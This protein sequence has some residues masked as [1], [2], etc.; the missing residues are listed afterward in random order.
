MPQCN[1]GECHM[2]ETHLIPNV[3]N[4]ILNPAKHSFTLYGD[5]YG[6]EDGTCIRD[7]VHVKD[8]ALAHLLALDA[9]RFGCEIFN[10]GYGQG[11]SNLEVIKAC[12]KACGEELVYNVSSR[13]SGDPPV[14]ITDARKVLGELGWEAKH[15]GL[16]EIISDALLWHKTYCL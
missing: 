7:Y 9:A 5:D 12:E 6:T 16:D 8:I 15:S 3:L 14:L 13:R 11:F 10:L 2:P 1:L 4:A